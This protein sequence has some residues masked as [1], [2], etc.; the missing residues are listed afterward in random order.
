ML[1]TLACA[2][3]A[4]SAPL[5][6]PGLR[7]AHA[8]STWYVSPSGTDS[9]GCG[10]GTAA[11]CKTIG[12]AIANAGA[13]DTVS[14]AAGTYHELVVV[15]KNLTL[16][17]AG[18]SHT[19]LDGTGLGGSVVTVGTMPTGPSPVE[20]TVSLRGL[21]IQHGSGTVLGSPPSSVIFGGG[22]LN[23]GTLTVTNCA[24][25]NNVVNSTSNVIAIGG[26][27]FTAGPLTVTTSTVSNNSITLARTAASTDTGAST[28]GFGGGIAAL[29]SIIASLSPVA[30]TDSTVSG[31]SISATSTVTAGTSNTGA[32]S[33]ALGGGILALDAPL[34]LAGSTVINNTA[35]SNSVGN[36]GSAATNTLGLT[37]VSEGGG[38]LAMPSLTA[39]NDTISGNSAAATTIGAA[40]GAVSVVEGGGV[41]TGG[42]VGLFSAG[43]SGGL[44]GQLSTSVPAL[45]NLLAQQPSVPP[46]IVV[47]VSNSTISNNTAKGINAATATRASA[48]IAFAGGILTDS[49]ISGQAPVQG[50]SLSPNIQ[51]VLQALRAG[52]THTRTTHPLEDGILASTVINGS[53]I[54]GN[55]ASTTGAAQAEALGGGIVNSSGVMNLANST[56][57]GNT[58]SNTASGPGSASVGGGILNEDGLEASNVTIAHNA[59]QASAGLGAGGAVFDEGEMILTNATINANSVTGTAIVPSLQPSRVRANPAA[60]TFGGGLFGGAELSNSIVAGNTL[61]GAVD[62]CDTGSSYG[63]LKGNLEDTNPSSCG[64]STANGD[65]VGQDPQ[66]GP[67]QDN[68]SVLAGAPSSLAP[69][70]TEAIPLT[71]PAANLGVAATCET[72]VGPDGVTTDTDERGLPR[73]SAPRGDCDSGAYDTG[74]DITLPATIAGAANALSAAGIRLGFAGLSGAGFPVAYITLQKGANTLVA[75]GPLSLDCPDQCIG[76]K[77]I[78]VPGTITLTLTGTVSSARGP[79]FAQ[80]YTVKAVITFTNSRLGTGAGIFRQALVMAHVQVF[81][82]SSATPLLDTTVSAPFNPQSAVNAVPAS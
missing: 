30:L 43:A 47:N 29:A 82:P 35:G 15:T 63:D 62:N 54:T 38:I 52:A 16:Q 46:S 26:G 69:L 61:N 80:G 81:A 53:A 27:I 59:A 39:S 11:A 55:T 70:F 42:S 5:A 58:A 7:A 19:F 31:N 37:S 14:I 40:Q 3:L 32:V 12:Q 75:R 13:G 23:W 73:H 57:S 1:R 21:S 72:L 68:G 66:L 41:V 6:A 56:V 71:S 18:A 17:G 64:F 4:L 76:T 50:S 9:A 8:A 34:T 36:A 79:L 45:S 33:E 20:P 25:S 78:P 28:I 10:T 65:V 51:S 49:S 22:V 60:P 48:S 2:A 74:D 67:L 77:A 44:L 24:I